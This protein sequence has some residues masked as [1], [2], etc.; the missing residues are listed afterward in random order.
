MRR[1]SIFL[2]IRSILIV[3]LGFTLV[4]FAE[5]RVHVIYFV[6]SDQ[7]PQNQVH[8]T[9]DTQ[10][11]AVQTFYAQQ[12]KAHGYGEKTFELETD[13]KGKVVTHTMIGSHPDA[14]YISGTLEKVE[15]EIQNR[16]NTGT[17]IYVVF[18]DLSNERVDGNCGIARY[19]GGPV[20]IPA[21]GD[22]IEGEAGID[23]I[24]HELGHA[25]NLI[26]D[27]RSENYIMSYGANRNEIS[28]CAATLLN[29]SP[30]FNDRRNTQNKAATIRMVTPE[31]YPK[32]IPNWKLEFDIA[33]PDKLYQVQF[34]LAVP[35]EP[36]S[37]FDCA[38]ILNGVT[39]KRITFEMPAGATV[40][41]VN[42]IWIRAVDING[43]VHTQAWTLNASEGETPIQITDPH[44]TETLLTLS[45][46]SP[47]TLTP[48]NP[49][50]EWQTWGQL[51]EKTPDGL[52]PR[53]P[54]G[55]FPASVFG[56]KNWKHFFYAHADSRIV[57]D[58]S[59]GNYERFH[60]Y[61]DMPNPCNNYAKL[62]VMFLAD[63][64][65]IYNSGVLQGSAGRHLQI[66]FDI[67]EGAETLTLKVDDL[68]D[69]GC[70]HF[71][72]GEPTLTHSVTTEP[73]VTTTPTTTT[74][75][76][77]GVVNLNATETMLTLGYEASDALRATNDPTEWHSWSEGTLEK[78][79]NGLLPQ[80]PN[81]FFR[82]EAFKG[83]N[84]THFFYAHA[85]STIIWDISS[86]NYERFHAYF[87]M[88]NPCGDVA[89]VVITFHADDTE[90][91]NSGVLKGE[92][93]RHSDI[94]FDIPEGNHKTLTLRVDD[95]GA[96]NWCDHFVFGEPTLTHNVTVTTTPTT[97]TPTAM[98]NT[99]VSLLPISGQSPNIGQL[100][101]L[102]VK[103]TN[104]KNV[105]GY[106]ATVQFDNTT[107]R[108][109]ESINS[110]YLPDGA[111]FVSPILEGNL[112]KLN[113]ASLAG[114]SNG[115]GT[116]ATL[117]F[118]IIAVK[119][120]ILTLSDVLLSNSTGETF[121]PQVE[122]SQITEP[123]KLIGDVN[124]DGTINIGDL[125]LVASNLGQT[126]QNA[127]DVNSDG[128]V[129]IADLVLVAGALGTSTAP[130]IH[131][132]ALEMLTATDVK[133][134]LSSAQ[135]LNL[136]DMKSQRGILLLQ[137]LLVALTPKETALLANYP[138][139]FNPETWIPYQLAKSTDVTLT[140][141]AINGQ[142]VVR[143]L[144]LGHQPAGIYQYRSRAAYWDGKNAVGESVAS[145]VY[146]YTLTAGDFT[147][148]RKM[149]I[150][151]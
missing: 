91:Y 117:T 15:S 24:A 18:V 131:P 99:T 58:I 50:I 43:N 48:T 120:S 39:N 78:T 136:T 90:I 8:S 14:H 80:I 42:H 11:K 137:Q 98:G 16:F 85:D 17:E 82:P 68:G 27:F 113:A 145:G 2:F 30:Y 57:W 71:V 49:K 86:G 89:D 108:Y 148:T 36:S 128:V 44:R 88:P 94:E 59:N 72:F 61:F 115:D 3:I 45:Y 126:G 92:A 112:V 6:P 141:Y 79:P 119:A 107:L 133:E 1:H 83:E 132:Q 56:G 140:I 135:Q 37:I 102:S 114:E 93:G 13:R 150:R 20:L 138:N 21:R 10:L 63:D 84:W 69:P 73:P 139:P 22:C 70:D 87:D 149:L 74:M 151:K 9:I 105:A 106:Q 146:F 34:E 130:S 143:T 95:L 123:T 96:P 125:V 66:T 64:T 31:T 55:L 76:S 77:D 100:L 62:T 60:A 65:E 110:D 101:K 127:A 33:D 25:F 104:G 129:N 40:S 75:S 142:Q 41:P 35:E 23:L 51:W 26:H 38:S 116:L 81:G 29:V 32:N 67:P 121:A 46:N 52:V 7:T 118:E 19:E 12:M 109:V 28:K 122:N 53:T 144:T 97:T 5:A 54:N 134:W 4:K 147:A 103:I 111:F 124:G 47:E